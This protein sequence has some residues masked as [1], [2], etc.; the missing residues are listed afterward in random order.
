MINF[1][2]LRK[3]LKSLSYEDFININNDNSKIKEAWTVD[4]VVKFGTHKKIEKDTL[5]N[6][7]EYFLVDILGNDLTVVKLTKKKYKTPNGRLVNAKI[8]LTLI[9]D[10]KKQYGSCING[11]FHIPLEYYIKGVK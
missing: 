2:K 1:D 5:V 9:N 10:C 11:Y 8:I 3:Y 6:Y 4:D 7:G